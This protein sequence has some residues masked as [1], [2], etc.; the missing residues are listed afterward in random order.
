MMQEN[1]R[2]C[3]VNAAKSLQSEAEANELPLL[4]EPVEAVTPSFGI[5]NGV[6]LPIAGRP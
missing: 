1:R 4:R 3:R 2:V 5:V 6:V